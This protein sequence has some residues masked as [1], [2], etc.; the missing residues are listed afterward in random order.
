MTTKRMYRSSSTYRHGTMQGN[1]VYFL[2]LN[3]D[4]YY[5][6]EEAPTNIIW[7]DPSVVTHARNNT[8][9]LVCSNST[10]PK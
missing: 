1:K 4:K 8:A 6:S 2:M 7:H 9:L 5:L 3:N 10:A